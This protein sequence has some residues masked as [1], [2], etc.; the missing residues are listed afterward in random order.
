[1]TETAVRT[2]SATE[3]LRSLLAALRV[4]QWVK[5]L[6]VIVPVILDHKLFDLPL[7]LRA[8]AAFAAF[9]CA[10]SGAYVLNDL[11]DLEADRRHR[12][13]RLRPFA[14]GTLSPAFGKL[15]A[16]LLLVTALLLAALVPARSFFMLLVL[17]LVV[18]TAYSVYL[19]RVA[20]VDV[21]LLAGLYTLRVLAGV[22]ATGVR[23]SAWLLAF[24]MFLFLSL[25]FLKRYA[26]VRG[27]ESS[28]EESIFR[29]GYLRGDREWLGSMGGAS[30]YLSVL[31]LALY[32]SSE[33]VVAL[34]HRP[35]VLWLV[36]PLLLFWISRMWLLGHR[37]R[38]HDD[39][40]VATARDPL[41]YVLGGL[42]AVILLA[43]M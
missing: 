24:S 18:T 16:P 43:A 17:Y 28:P 25:A 21:L 32:I 27:A 12:T 22:A 9:C 31:V 33:Q 4:H 15:L 39:P 5:N 35:V 38:L 8:L 7:V 3:R 19:K 10:A 26:E 37:G 34:Y 6:L 11:L 20:V 23:F 36:C 1:M 14:S 30:G 40:I 2:A 13:K 29:R 42:V 41:S